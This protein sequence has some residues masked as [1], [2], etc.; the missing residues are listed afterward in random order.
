M[1]II[2]GMREKALRGGKEMNVLPVGLNE[3][4]KRQLSAQERWM[5]SDVEAALVEHPE[6]LQ[7]VT[8]YIRMEL[9][10]EGGCEKELRLLLRFIERV[11]KGKDI[12]EWKWTVREHIDRVFE[13]IE[14]FGKDWEVEEASLMEG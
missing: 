14:R 6:I 9:E 1:I 3:L 11:P 4:R 13:I 5:V 7:D 12:E 8:A 10:A 2:Q